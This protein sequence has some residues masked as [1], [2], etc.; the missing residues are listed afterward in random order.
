MKDPKTLPNYYLHS[1]IEYH[2]N[3]EDCQCGDYCRC[4]V[5]EIDGFSNS[6]YDCSKIAE[7]GETDLEKALLFLYAKSI[8]RL[9]DIN[10]RAVGGY[11]GQELECDG[12]TD[13]GLEALK[14]FSL[15]TD[16]QKL[17]AVLDAENGRFKLASSILKDI[18][19]IK[20]DKID[21]NLI[22]N[23]TPKALNDKKLKEYKQHFVDSKSLPV[24]CLVK[25]EKDSYRL[26]DGRH[27][28]TAFTE[29]FP[30]KLIPAI[31]IE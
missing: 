20:F 24:I 11:Y 1:F 29:K 7:L 30:K 3:S 23:N 5:I 28:F 18:T 12:F 26:I 25:K 15:F 14:T 22:H 2:S 9:E 13:S 4:G 17:E 31:V 6:A 8:L 16:L 19:S 10:Y 27:R 21:R